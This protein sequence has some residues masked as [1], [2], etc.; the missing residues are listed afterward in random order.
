MK[1]ALAVAAL[2]IAIGNTTFAQTKNSITKSAVT[3]KIKNLGFNTRGSFGAVSGDIQFDPQ[4][5]ATS[6]I[7]ASID[8]AS[9]NTDNE[10][11]DTHLKSEDYFDVAK[12][13]KIS[14]KS[15]SFKHGSADNYTGQFN[16]TIKDKTKLIS[17]PF[18]YTEAG[19]AG[20][21]KGSFKIKRTDF[22]IGSKNVIL[23]DEATVTVEAETGK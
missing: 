12:Y 19:G 15:V 16:V 13:P 8:V 17:V 9:V 3:F 1:K 14:M 23:S 22:G 18:V 6:S 2:I 21:F 11:R 10:K 20:F 7:V 4:K 5:L